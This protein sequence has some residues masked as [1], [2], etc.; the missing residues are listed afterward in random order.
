MQRRRLVWEIQQVKFCG[1]Q[2]SHGVPF[3][4]SLFLPSVGGRWGGRPKLTNCHISCPEGSGSSRM[5]LQYFPSPLSLSLSLPFPLESNRIWPTKR[6]SLSSNYP[7]AAVRVVASAG[8]RWTEI[9]SAMTTAS[10]AKVNLEARFL[11][12]TPPYLGIL[13]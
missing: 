2:S 10:L 11:D 12:L 3:S 4:P 9:G 8:K 13:F 6:C 7:T 5:S 1:R